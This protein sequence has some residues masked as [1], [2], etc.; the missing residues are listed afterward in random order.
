MPKSKDTADGQQPATGAQEQR[1]SNVAS[2]A[3]GGVDVKP[4]DF[5][6][7]T[8]PSNV[9]PI[10][11][12]GHLLDVKFEAEAILGRTVLSI[13]EILKLGSGS[14][15]HLNRMISEPVE[16]FVQGVK[17][18]DGEVVVVGDQFAFRV[19]NITRPASP[20]P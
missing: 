15:V 3:G 17:V 4:A 11:S 12:L 7:L 18:A 2:S 20:I 19:K 10:G 5:Q 8:Q 1:V 13:E 6:E 9:D 16:L 14:V